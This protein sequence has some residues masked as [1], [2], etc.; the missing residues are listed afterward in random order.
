M[1]QGNSTHIRELLARPTNSFTE[2]LCKAEEKRPLTLEDATALLDGAC[3]EKQ[4][5][6]LL[7]TAQK[8][9]AAVFGEKVTIFV[10]LYISNFCRNI[11]PYCVDRADNREQ[12]RVRLTDE[13][14][15]AE[16][17]EL[18]RRGFTGC[19]IVAATDPKLTAED[20]AQKIR[21][22]KEHGLRSVLANIDSMEV[23][24]Y[25]KLH[26]AGLDAYIFFQ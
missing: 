7:Q 26:D 19:E 8:I 23:E 1:Y 20:Y 17:Q 15:I 21:L 11:C 12:K 25:Q 22:A 14:F 4:R 16:V 3:E 2:A 18:T 24:D 6:M 9:T 13:Q 10:P 5:D